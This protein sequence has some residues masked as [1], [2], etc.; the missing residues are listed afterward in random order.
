MSRKQKRLL[1]GVFVAVFWIGVWELLALYVNQVLLIPAPHTV[2]VTLFH[3]IKTSDFW[4]AV[5]LSLLRIMAGFAVGVMMGSLLAFLTHRFSFAASLLH[6]LR[7]GIR[8][9][10]VA[11][12]IILALV[13]L[14]T[15]SLPAF[16]AF[17][18][19]L[20]IMWSG[21]EQGLQQIEPRLLDM[22]QVFQLGY[23]QT[24]FQVRIPAILPHFRTAFVNSLG[25]AWKSGI[26]AEVICR[27]ED[28]IGRMLQEA[29]IY[30]E[31]PEVFAWTA[32]VILLSLSIEKILTLVVNRQEKRRDA[33]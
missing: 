7:H 1:R 21:V 5:S 14:P 8:A 17:L 30:L 25:L 27:P 22:A 16:I 12:F 4:L 26:A 11:S 13:W 24:L 2:A 10:P 19:V 23:R 33:A 6:P 28:S 32:V 20:P 3:L 31:T 15:N 9:I 29:K 18:M